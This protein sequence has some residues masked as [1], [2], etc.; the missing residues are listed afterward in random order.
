MVKDETQA[1]DEMV[2]N[3]TEE[4]FAK[5][6]SSWNE[7]LKKRARSLKRFYTIWTIVFSALLAL[8]LF[9]VTFTTLSAVGAI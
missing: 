8:A 4:Q 2:G 5:I 3:L 6:E 7:F 1:A 9:Y